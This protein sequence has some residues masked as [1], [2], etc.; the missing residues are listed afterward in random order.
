MRS[1]DKNM[2]LLSLNHIQKK[3]SGNSILK[4]VSLSLSESEVVFL[5]GPSGCGK[6][7][8]LRI[9]AGFEQADQGSMQIR[10]RLIFGKGSFVPPQGRHLGYVVQ[11]GV[12][13]PHL[14]VYR[15]IA[16]GVGDGTGR[17]RADRERIAEVMEL[18]RISEL[19]NQMP[20]QMSGGQ[21]QRV[22]LARAL[23]PKPEVL[24]LDEPFSAL[25]EHLRARIRS[26]I[27]QI[28]HQ[29]GAA[30]IIV[31]HD[32]KEALSCADRVGLI[33]SG[34]L[35][36][37]DTPEEI[38]HNPTSP[39]VARFIHDECLLLPARL[40][41]DG[42]YAACALADRIPIQN[43]KGARD[44]KATGKLLIRRTQLQP[45]LPSDQA[46]LF[47]AVVSGVKFH[48]SSIEL[49]ALAEGINFSMVLSDDISQ[50]STDDVVGVKVMGKC[51]YFAS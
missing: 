34:R 27:I 51:S 6:T 8:L 2:S 12:L 40:V 50:Y 22:A 29:S 24:L 26:E 32:R 21:Q 46:S 17:S 5:L 38:Y 48:G 31:T 39:D 20:H 37:I 45:V 16:Y 28:L 11:E 47:S 18:T 35:V 33:D 7:T 1:I 13:F 44:S 49:S 25:D 41:E 42:S 15:N 14:N 36:Q 4:G 9:I 19:A 30:A 3:F 43:Y 23:A 10:D